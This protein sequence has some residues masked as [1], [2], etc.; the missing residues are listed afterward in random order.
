MSHLERSSARITA[1]SVWYQ[2]LPCQLLPSRPSPQQPFKGS[3][4]LACPAV[5]MASTSHQSPLPLQLPRAPCA[6]HPP[7]SRPICHIG[8][9]PNSSFLSISFLFLC[10]VGP[11]SLGLL[12]GHTDVPWDTVNVIAET[13]QDR[14]PSRQFATVRQEHK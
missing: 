3:S 10:S 9:D 13:G 12:G 11:C 14:P 7:P 1:R 5:L 2:P 8:K 4:A 6:Q